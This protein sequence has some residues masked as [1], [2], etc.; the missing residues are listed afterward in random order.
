M[1]SAL[2]LD[3]VRRQFPVFQDPRYSRQI[4]CENAGGSYACRQTIGHLEA[5]YRECKMQP[6]GRHPTSRLGGERMDAALAAMAGWLGV[7]EDWLHIGPSTTQ[8]VYVLAQSVGQWLQPGDE[9]IVTNQDHEANSGAWRR[10]AERG[11]RVHEWRVDPHSGSLTPDALESLLSS[12]TRLLAFPHCSNI[13]AEINPVAAICDRARRVGAITVV[14]GV[15][16]AG[17][18]FPHLPSLGA[19]VYLFSTYKTYGPHQGV[20]VLRP[21]LARQLPAQCHYFNELLPGK[22]LTPAGP[23]HAQIAACA[24]ISDYFEALCEHHGLPSATR[25]E[26][27]HEMLRAAEERLLAPLLD[28]CAADRRVRLLGPAELRQRA[29]TV[30]LVPQGPAPAE[31]AAGLAERDIVAGAGHFY[32]PRLLEALDVDPG[33][34]VL[35]LS[36]LHYNSGEEVDRL[37]AALDELL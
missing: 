20:M 24:G 23:D 6:Y 11:I 3:F 21:E 22:R 15:G 5:F 12:R 27:L 37:L 33:R 35:R 10:L 28:W 14:D 31:V 9:I 19:D 30:A 36:L 25:Q 7:A 8:N 26:A 1:P 18:G 16:Y 4:H 2:D 17:H 32:A 13:V 29:P 34:G